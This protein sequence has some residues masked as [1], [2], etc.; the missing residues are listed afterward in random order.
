[1]HEHDLDLIAALA[2]GSLPDEAEARALVEVC[3]VCR[4]EYGTQL[5][6]LAWVA[7]TPRVEM[8]ELERAALHRD[9]WT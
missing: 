5:E 4:S 9:L 2:D 3:D 7:S 1:M 6:V 8:T